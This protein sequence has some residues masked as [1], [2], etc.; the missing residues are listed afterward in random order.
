LVERRA[1]P[2]VRD[3]QN[4]SEDLISLRFS[5][6]HDSPG[7][8][9]RRASTGGAFE[10]IFRPTHR[11][12]GRFSHTISEN[13]DRSRELDQ[14]P[15]SNGPVPLVLPQIVDQSAGGELEIF[16]EETWSELSLM[17]FCRSGGSR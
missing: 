13:H 12:V 8:G 2:Q 9:G 1:V 16:R 6:G 17:V 7:K 15:R 14:Q 3:P 10:R 4:A 11:I 5:S